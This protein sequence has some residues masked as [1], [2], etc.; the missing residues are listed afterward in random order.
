MN[1]VN[2]FLSE[3]FSPPLQGE[4][5]AADSNFIFFLDELDLPD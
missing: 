5:A 4:V 1:P 2:N 3:C